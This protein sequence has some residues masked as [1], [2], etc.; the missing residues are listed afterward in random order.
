MGWFKRSNDE[1]EEE[2]VDIGQKG[3]AIVI[4]GCLV[5][6]IAAAVINNT[7]VKKLNTAIDNLIRIQSV[8]TK[9]VKELKEQAVILDELLERVIANEV[10]QAQPTVTPTIKQDKPLASRGAAAPLLMGGAA[11]FKSYM[12]YRCITY[13]KS[14]QYKY[15]LS[16]HTDEVGLRRAPNGDYLVALGTGWVKH[17]GQRFEV[18]LSGGRLFTCTVGDF[19]D[20]K[21]TDASTHKFTHTGRVL[22]FLID[23][24][25]MAKS[26]LRAGDVSSLNLIGTIVYIRSI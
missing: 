21:D 2:W 16:G 5:F 4:A 20:D 7:K 19:K 9:E 18:Q 12:D 15:R 26:V 24:K 8:Q 23:S 1:H 11:A 10:K 13:K 14:P 22:E 25:V 17:I 3:I 6:T